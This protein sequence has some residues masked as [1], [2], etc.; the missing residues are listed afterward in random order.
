MSG[1]LSPFM[2]LHYG[3]GVESCRSLK[4]GVCDLLGTLIDCTRFV[5]NDRKIT[6]RW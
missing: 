3:S 5:G 4:D 1:G 2:F 6:P